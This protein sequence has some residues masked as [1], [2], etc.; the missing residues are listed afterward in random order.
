[1][2]RAGG[3]LKAEA[4]SARAADAFGCVFRG[5]RRRMDAQRM[6]RRPQGESAAE[7][8]G[9]RHSKKRGKLR[10]IGVLIFHSGACMEKEKD[11]REGKRQI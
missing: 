6:R 11:K 3:A 8:H 4:S 5:R 1:M 10:Q 7:E 9:V 2:T